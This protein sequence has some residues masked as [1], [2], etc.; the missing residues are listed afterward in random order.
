MSGASAGD[1]FAEDSAAGST[2]TASP[3]PLS[4]EERDARRRAILEKLRTGTI[5]I[6]EAEHYLI[7][8]G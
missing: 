5:S 6:E 8:L 2:G 3:P 1:P 4:R 7:E